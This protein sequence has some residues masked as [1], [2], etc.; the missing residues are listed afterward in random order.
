MRYVNLTVVIGWLLG[1]I[2][3]GLAACSDDQEGDVIP[4]G[5]PEKQNEY[6]TGNDLSRSYSL[7][8]RVPTFENETFHA[9]GY[10]YDIT[11][12][13]AHPEGIRKK[14][15]DPQ[16]FEDDHYDEVMHHW[17]MFS[18]RGLGTKI[19]T[20]EEVK[21]QLLEDM[22]I[23]ASDIGTEYKNAFRGIFD[24]PF[25]DD[26]A[27]TH[28][29]Y[30]YAIDAFASS[31]YE[32]YFLFFREKDILLLQ[33]YLTEEFKS[34]L[35][36]KSAQEIIE[37]YGTHVMVDIEVG[38]RQD[39][40]YRAGSED[41]LQRRMVYASGKFL[42]S[43]PGLW[44][45]PGPDTYY[46]KENLYTQYVSGVDPVN[47][48][49]AWMFDITNYSE[50]LKFEGR[51]HAIENE[52]LVLIN[53]GSR[54]RYGPLIPVYEFVSDTAPREALLQAYREYLSK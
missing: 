41:D 37:L 51:E 17:G 25:E 49:N 35:A 45:S 36:T 2:L 18:H 46:D 42:G 22:K 48:P 27:F 52:S 3:I 47:K 28:L 14:V 20:K 23:K 44:M 13:Y 4:P 7:V 21:K 19:G 50:E 38:W 32:H 54:S 53:W 12:K 11:G 29:T 1:L 26:T 9:L 24:T 30:H 8:K 34:D 40:Y 5:P 31:W 10:G 6:K 16:K 15:L 33:K 43:S 39:Y